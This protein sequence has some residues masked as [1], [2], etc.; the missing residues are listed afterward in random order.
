MITNGINSSFKRG[1]RLITAQVKRF[2]EIKKPKYMRLEGVARSSVEEATLDSESPR[3]LYEQ[4][5]RNL[6]ERIDA[7]TLKPG[8][9]L[10]SEKELE[11][12]FGVSR[13]T[14]R[15]ALQDLTHEERITRV[16]GK[17]S[18]VL[19]PK[20]E[21]LTALTSFSE[22]MRAQGCKPSYSNARVSLVTPPSK[23]AQLLD[24]DEGAQTL[25][26]E[27]LMLAD[28]L[29][30]AIQDSYLP[31]SL[32]TDTISL[33]TNELLNNL[34][35]YKI[36]ELEVGIRLNRAEEWVDASRALS[37]EAE[38]LQIEEGDFVLLIE[39]L[40]FSKANQPVEYVKMI[41]PAKR[42]RY[43]VELFRPPK[44]GE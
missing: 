20:I 14:V 3:P 41:F 5:K 4:L 25:R 31:H 13:A 15:R 32:L 42:Y 33:F 43:K 2:Q 1:L 22:N 37:D 29:P 11:R 21:P 9:R 38:L 10:P 23:V 7:G 44:H 16:A 28:D 19:H 6:L 30:M 26:I 12:E 40:T 8:D 24:L 17:G 36:L 18:F 35:L 34:S 27:R 39:R